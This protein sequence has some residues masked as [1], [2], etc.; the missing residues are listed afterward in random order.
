[1][2]QRQKNKATKAERASFF[3]ARTARTKLREGHSLYKDGGK[4]RSLSPSA[5]LNSLSED[6]PLTTATM[7]HMLTDLADTLQ[8]NMK[9]Q[10]QSLTADLRKDISDIGQ[11]TGHMEQKLD[12]CADAHNCL[13]NKVPDYEATLNSYKIKVPDMEDRSR[14]N[15]IRIRSIL[16]TVLAAGLNN[17]LQDMFPTLTL[18]IHPDQL[19]VDRA[20]QL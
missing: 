13:A 11:R 19:I 14:R 16:E 5:S 18:A 6:Q 15:N 2:S 8:F 1:M 12:E 17:Y 3:L 10:L 9:K 7:R 4:A 20:H